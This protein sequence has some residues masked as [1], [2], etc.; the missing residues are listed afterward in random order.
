M[1]EFLLHRINVGC[2]SSP[3]E[4]WLNYDNTPAI[5][6]ANSPLKYR[7]S[8]LFGLLNEAHI[9]NIE[10]NKKNKIKYADVTKSIP[11]PS[12]SVEAIYTSH[13]LE[14][15]SRKGAKNFLCEAK[16]ILKVDG[17]LRV[18]I[19]D[20]KIYLDKYLTDEDADEFM[21]GILTEA[22]PI[23]TFKQKVVL[24]LNG[25]RHHQWMYD[26]KS[27]SILFKEAG[28]RNIKIC[29]EGQTTIKNPSGLD[30][31]ERGKNSVYVEGAK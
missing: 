22:P 29:A 24:F 8:K 18:S 9:A 13:M 25:Y 27:L 7:I 4:G 3:S 30:L 20:L 17:V 15:L 5:K 31:Y 10:W 2:G 11:L 1:E 12:N 21:T 14:H 23:D 28:L 19:P 6:L 16:R 26:G